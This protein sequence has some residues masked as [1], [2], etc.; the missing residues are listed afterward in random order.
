MARNSQKIDQNP[1]VA[2]RRGCHPFAW[3]AMWKNA[4]SKGENRENPVEIGNQRIQSTVPEDF[5]ITIISIIYIQTIITISSYYTDTTGWMRFWWNLLVTSSW[6]GPTWP[7]KASVDGH[8]SAAPRLSLRLWLHQSL[9]PN[10]IH[11]LVLGSIPPKYCQR[12]VW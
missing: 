2:P 10:W 5:P 6:V 9:L 1:V 8:T 3:P 7:L 11:Q 12:I 4:I